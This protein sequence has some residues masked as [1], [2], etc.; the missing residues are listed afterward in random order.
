VDPAVDWDIY[1]VN[2]AGQIVGQGATFGTTGRTHCSSTRAG[3][4]KPTS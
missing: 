1:V 4:Y 3:S 2:S